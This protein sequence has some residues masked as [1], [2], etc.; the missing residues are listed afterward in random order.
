MK[1]NEL[2]SRPIKDVIA[3]MDISEFKVHT[4]TQTNEVMCI[5]MKYMPKEASK[6][7]DK[8]KKLSIM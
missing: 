3:D 2:Y 8:S 1:L 4:N 5:E 6:T 7:A